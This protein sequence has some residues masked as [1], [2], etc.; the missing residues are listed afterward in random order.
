MPLNKIVKN[1]SCVWRTVWRMYELY[2]GN[3]VRL[4]NIELYEFSC[5]HDVVLA[6]RISWLL[7]GKCILLNGFWHISRLFT[8]YYLGSFIPLEVK[9][10]VQQGQQEQHCSQST[11]AVD[12]LNSRFN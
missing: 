12:S 10:T 2:F 9:V 3:S 7:L 5:G 8:L 6:I 11:F 4:V 1:F